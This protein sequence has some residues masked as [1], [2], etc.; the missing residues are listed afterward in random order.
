[1]CIYADGGKMNSEELIKII[2]EQQKTIDIFI[3]WKSEINK[4][5]SGIIRIIEQQE[6]QTNEQKQLLLQIQDLAVTNRWRIESLPYELNDPDYNDGVFKPKMFTREETRRLIIEEHRS[7]SRFGDGEF[8][9]ACN[10]QRW[11]FQH[12]NE[13]LAQKLLDILGTD[14]EDFL[15]GLNPSF[16]MNLSGISEESA[17]AVRSYMR[18]EVRRQH[19]RLLKKDKVYADALLHN[20]ET[21]EDVIELK[22][23]WNGRDCI[24]VEGYQ[25]RMGVGNDLFDNCSSVSR[26][27][28]PATDAFDRYEE[29]LNEVLKQPKDRLVLI[30]LGQTATALAYDIY[31]E[32]YQAVDIGRIDLLYEKFIA[33]LPDLYS[34]QIPYKH[35]NIDE[36]GQRRNIED[37]FDVQYDKEIIARL[38]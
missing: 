24:F 19:A 13:H 11:N 21:H 16:Y 28:G 35:C 9:I 22:K 5:L 18:P 31:K 1:M 33:G 23:I 8:A 29:I 32:G 4:L 17:D 34:L 3:S 27:L 37:I 26:I 20:I 15:V 2:N 7:I 38:Y 36:V 30:A 12:T 10:I 14:D 6:K 25:T